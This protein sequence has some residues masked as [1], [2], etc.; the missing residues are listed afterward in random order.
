[1][2]EVPFER[3]KFIAKERFATLFE[4][5]SASKIFGEGMEF[6]EVA[7]YA[8]GDDV[9]RIN[10]IATA[11]SASLQKNLH[12][13]QKRLHLKALF[14]LEANLLCGK[15]TEALNHLIYLHYLLGLGAFYAGHYLEIEIITDT[16]R[17][18]LK[19]QAH[20][21]HIEHAARLIAQSTLFKRRATG[22]S[23]LK[24]ATPSPRALTFIIGSFFDKE[25]FA[26]LPRTSSPIALALRCPLPQERMQGL[27]LIDPATSNRISGANASSQKYRKELR[28]HDEALRAKAQKHGVHL[29]FIDDLDAAAA[30][31]NLLMRKALR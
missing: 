29:G 17:R 18:Y 26:H 9:R 11:K 7:P 10:W 25:P 2:I 24:H 28:K 3:L 21:V 19:P 8:L 30:Q 12:Y 31:I 1:M 27:D 23:L 16:S 22:A 13:G 5:V 6:A 4:G 14:L 20:A 15:P